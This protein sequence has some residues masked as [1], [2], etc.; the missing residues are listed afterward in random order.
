MDERA[1]CSVV[2]AV[3]L[4]QT[5]S[6]FSNTPLLLLR[7]PTTTSDAPWWWWRWLGGGRRC[8][9]GATRTELTDLSAGGSPCVLCGPEPGSQSCALCSLVSCGWKLPRGLWLDGLAINAKQPK[10]WKGKPRVFWVALAGT[11]TADEAGEGEATGPSGL[12]A[13][14]SRRGR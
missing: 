8:V 13:A 2:S 1:S 7:P 10:K 3:F 4:T 11:E 12:E 5:S 14:F 9:N 6:L